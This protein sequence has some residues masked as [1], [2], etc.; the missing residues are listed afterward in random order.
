M[1]NVA[2][3]SHH[4]HSGTGHAAMNGGSNSTTGHSHV[5]L[6]SV[7]RIRPLLKKERDDKVLLEA[8]QHQNGMRSSS[9][10][11]HFAAVVVLDPH[12]ASLTSPS[13]TAGASGASSQLRGRVDSDGTTYTVPTEY[14]F[15]HVLPETT[16]QDKIY[17][18]LGL[19]M[20]T[21]AMTSLKT[22]AVIATTANDRSKSSKNHLL[23][24]MG[25]LG[26]GKT[27]TCLG[28]TTV[29]KRRAS[30]DGLVPRLLDSLFSQSKHHASGNGSKGFA[31]HVSMIQVTQP[32]G[33]TDCQIQ[34]LLASLSSS[35]SASGS[36]VSPKRTF[37]VRSMAARFESVRSPGQS[38]AASAEETSA[39]LDPSN[40]QPSVHK[41]RDVVH[42]RE[43]LQSGLASSQRLAKGNQNFHLFITMQPVLDGKT[44]GD[45]ISILDMA[46]LEKE[47][48]SQSRGKDSVA[49]MNQAASAAV[50][51]CLRIMMHNVNIKSGK[52]GTPGID[53]TCPDDDVSELSFVSQ[54]KDPVQRKMKP[55]PFRQHMVTMLL[56]P[57]FTNST[58]VKV[59]LLLAA[60]PGHVDVSQ[61][62]MLL[63][64]I[65]LLHG[66]TLA[67]TNAIVET[68][69]NMP[70]SIQETASSVS[71]DESEGL[72]FP[73]AVRHKQP[74]KPKEGHG[75]QATSTGVLEDSLVLTESLPLTREVLPSTTV[76]RGKV[77][78]AS[79]RP[80]APKSDDYG[81]KQSSKHSTKY[82]APNLPVVLAPSAP[83]TVEPSAPT[84]NSVVPSNVMSPRDLDFGKMIAADFP[85]V[86][87]P[88][89]V[90]HTHLTPKGLQ[91]NSN[92]PL[93]HETSSSR[94]SSN[95]T[96]DTFTDENLL[97]VSEGHNHHK[98]DETGRQL[99]TNSP[100]CRSPLQNA[101]KIQPS[102]RHYVRKT[103]HSISPRFARA[104]QVEHE[105]N[106]VNHP[107]RQERQQSS[108]S[109][110]QD[111]ESSGE[112]D[113]ELKKLEAKLQQALQENNALQQLCSQLEEE[114]AELK[115][116]VRESGRKVL[117]SRWTDQDEKE[118]QNSRRLRREDQNLIKAPI[119]SHLEKV[120]YTYEIKNQWCMTNKPHFSLQLPNQFQ[121]AHELDIRDKENAEKEEAAAAIAA[122]VN[123]TTPQHVTTTAIVNKT[124][125]ISPTHLAFGQAKRRVMSPA[126][127]LEPTG[128]AALKK[129]A[130]GNRC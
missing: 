20:A 110:G 125:G 6:E 10:T 82:K 71:E 65:E 22:S 37:N 61:K 5:E 55:V 84:I 48:R 95:K 114:N 68:G 91:P 7:L 93:D 53:V 29:A 97:Y 78:A 80:S 39:E 99:P 107:S 75:R 90:K 85:G 70:R 15:N 26:S 89:A 115:K 28:G 118:F 108:H 35:S 60:Y 127:V 96:A 43:V 2:A 31:V 129:L 45:K 117:Q 126:K 46:G 130:A 24:C 105:A 66:S 119:R 112:K 14:H 94:K 32:K 30:Q 102:E 81:I 42:A 86:N 104:M 59:T 113:T 64:D 69:L 111:S 13:M 57:L 16:S 79:V 56:N 76:H 52:N 98:F 21:A 50:L 77:V 40:L 83:P 122:E 92:H 4:H 87:V 100:L 18:T 116:T 120:N 73:M 88:L 62:R 51:H 12:F 33:N 128:L 106:V 34:D 123:G 74:N 38:K 58:S 3:D 25:V 44:F 23:V 63:Q 41:C 47:K 17:Y 11:G 1:R 67:N 9:K 36:Y 72:L 49:S 8:Q 54:A 27:Y 19:P 121:R 103:K 124:A 101:L 109:R